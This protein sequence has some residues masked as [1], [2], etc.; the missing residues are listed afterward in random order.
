MSFEIKC[1]NDLASWL[2]KYQDRTKKIIGQFRDLMNPFR[3][4]DL[5]LH[6]MNGSYSLKMVLPA[7][8]PEMTYENLEIQEGGM[9]STFFLKLAQT[10]DEEERKR[11]RQALLDYCELDTLAMVKILEKLKMYIL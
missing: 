11:L 4:R 5:Y 6:Q 2:P 8:I 10:Q 3:S 1:L 7:L 9:A